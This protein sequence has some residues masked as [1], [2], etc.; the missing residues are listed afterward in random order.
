MP[1]RR[2]CNYG[3]NILG[4]NESLIIRPVENENEL[5]LFMSRGDSFER[6]KNKIAITL[7]VII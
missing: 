2:G 1:R 4:K 5:M 7:Q 3:S 6:F